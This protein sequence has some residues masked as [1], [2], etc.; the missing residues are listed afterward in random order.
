MLTDVGLSYIGE[1]SPRVRSIVLDNLVVSNQGILDFSK[2]CPSLEFL[3]IHR[4]CSFNVKT[5]ALATRLLT[6]LKCLWVYG[7]NGARE[8]DMEDLS[9]MVRP[10]WVHEWIRCRSG[11]QIFLRMVTTYLHT[12]HMVRR[13]LIN[14]SMSQFRPKFLF[15]A[16]RN[17][18]HHSGFAYL[19]CSQS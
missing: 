3:A 14:P 4:G 17:L 1:Y 2:G 13:D 6:S 19:L 16:P 7:Y 11:W 12:F 8:E 10:H 15:I 9:A 5:L 18:D